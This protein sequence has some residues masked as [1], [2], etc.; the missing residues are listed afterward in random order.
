MKYLLSALIALMFLSV[1]YNYA[2]SLSKKEVIALN[3]KIKD[4]DYLGN[5]SCD[6]AFAIQNGKYGFIDKKGKFVIPCVNPLTENISLHYSQFEDGVFIGENTIIDKS[7]R[8]IENIDRKSNFQYWGIDNERGSV[9]VIQN[10]KHMI[11]KDGKKFGE[12]SNPHELCGAVLISRIRTD[13]VNYFGS[14]DKCYLTNI[15]SK[16]PSVYEVQFVIPI[17]QKNGSYWFC[18]GK[19]NKVGIIDENFKEVVPFVFDARTEVV[20]CGYYV[21]NLLTVQNGIVLENNGNYLVKDFNDKMILPFECGRV[22]VGSK[23][24]YAQKSNINLKDDHDGFCEVFD[25]KGN[26]IKELSFGKN[27]LRMKNGFWQFEDKDGNKLF[28]YKIDCMSE[29]LWDEYC[30]VNR[31]DYYWLLNSNGDIVVD[32]LS[33]VYR[34]RDVLMRIY[35]KNNVKNAGIKGRSVVE[36]HSDLVFPENNDRTLNLK[37]KIRSANGKYKLYDPD[38]KQGPYMLLD[39]D[40]NNLTP[41]GCDWIGHFSEGLILVKY[42][43]RYY[44]LNE[45]GEGLPKEAYMMK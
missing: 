38:E 2:Q 5:F 17:K 43:G 40:G 30:I 41:M 21:P 24:I 20:D 37:Y 1:E 34:D 8:V 18:A 9:Y 27:Y 15:L 22:N 44:Y 16:Q 12:Y 32:S 42:K 11:F 3:E 35:D 6:R 14:S 13:A 45:K 29:L 33:G 26:A 31:D 4:I 39:P 7:G 10:D 28:P 19:N 36:A 25:K 23:Y